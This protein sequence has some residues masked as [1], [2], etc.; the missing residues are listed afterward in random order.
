MRAEQVV[1]HFDLPRRAVVEPFGAEGNINRTFLVRSG[2]SEFLL[3]RLNPHVFPFPERVMYGMVM[4][5]AA[6]EQ[7]PPP[8]VRPELVRTCEGH[9]YLEPEVGPN[10]EREIWRLM[11]RIRPCATYKRLSESPTPFATARECGRGLAIFSSA[12]CSV[13]PE[14]LIGSLPGYRD[15]RL[16][17]RLHHSVLAQN[18]TLEQ[19]EELLPPEPDRRAATEKHFLVHLDQDEYR[20]RR[21]DPE[22]ARAIELSLEHEE[23]ALTLWR[24][25]EAGEV[26]PTAIHGDPKVENFLFDVD[27]GQVK[28]LVDLDTIMPFTWLADWGDMVRSLSNPAGEKEEDLAKVQVDW[29]VIE[30]MREG[31]LSSSEGLPA[32]ELD[33]MPLAALVMTLEQAVRFLTDYLR[34]DTYYEL[35]PRD[36]RDLNRTRALVQFRLFEQLLAGHTG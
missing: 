16:Y 33:L 3:Q 6:Q 12:L 21:A 13:N 28:A 36:P 23:L 20:R 29:Q 30:A 11:T 5:L 1:G 24:K 7:A 18:R 19:V 2:G 31:F 8:W 9:L 10:E 34:G 22:V 14:R 15:T 27:S 25:L 35:R 17:Y 32:H 26:A 4:A